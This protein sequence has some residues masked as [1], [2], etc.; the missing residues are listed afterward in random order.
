MNAAVPFDPKSVAQSGEE[1][2]RD[3]YQKEYERD[4]FGKFVAVN[5]RNG[6]ASLGDTPEQALN[7]A[8]QTDPTGLFHLMRVGFAALR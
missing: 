8:R 2:Y 7:S 3:K 5:V 4:H 1:I 6:N